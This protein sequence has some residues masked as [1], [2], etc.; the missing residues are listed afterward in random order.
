M[1]CPKCGTRNIEAAKFC[2]LCGT[3]FHLLSKPA[4]PL[5]MQMNYGRA[6]RPLFI[7]VGFLFIAFA[8]IF[9]HT[10]FFWWML[11]PAF[12]LI[13]KGTRRLTQMQ[14]AHAYYGPPQQTEMLNQDTPQ[15]IPH[16]NYSD[17]RARPTGEL[18]PPPSVTENTTKLLDA[19]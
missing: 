4:L 12:S 1:Y 14:A 19:N 17:V 10:G 7:G 9:S 8:S 15:Q 13:S 6:F 5:P 18:I 2:R 11:F 3:A 16:A